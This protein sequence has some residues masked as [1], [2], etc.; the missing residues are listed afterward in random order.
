MS[1]TLLAIDPSKSNLGWAKFI[2]GNLVSV[3]SHSFSHCKTL[4]EFLHAFKNWYDDAVMGAGIVAYEES[5]PR[6]MRHAEIHYGMIAVMHLTIEGR[7]L[8]P[9]NWSTAKKQLVGTSKASK[10]E[11]LAAA[12]ELY[13]TM[14]VESHDEADAIA[15]GISAYRIS[16]SEI[17]PF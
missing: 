9:I 15:I 7:T 17:T 14:D 10:A 8:V 5:K 3:G 6:N 12:Q 4:T 13:P 1:T 11:M 2:D 16:E